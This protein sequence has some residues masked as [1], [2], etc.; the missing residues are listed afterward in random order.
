[1]QFINSK[2]EFKTYRDSVFSSS[3]LY[4]TGT[5]D[6]SISSV[7]RTLDAG[8][9]PTGLRG[10]FAFVFQNEKRV[11]GAVDHVATTNLFYTNSHICHIF[12]D[13]DDLTAK[14]KYV[15]IEYQ[16]RF[17]WGG[18]VGERTINA[19]I[20]RLEPGTYFEKDLESNN[21]SIHT[22][23]DLYTHHYDPSISVGDIADITEQIIEEQTREPF[24]LLWSSGTDSNCILGFI[25]KLNRTDNCRLI[26]LYSEAS[27]TDERPQCK[28]LESVYGLEAEYKDLGKF[29]GITD[30]VIGR[31]R[32]D[33]ESVEYKKNF[34]RTWRGFWFEPNVFQKYTTLYDMGVHTKPTFTGE[35]GDQIFGSR[36]GKL[37]LNYLSHVPNPT[38]DDIGELFVSAD[39]FRFKRA[40]TIQ[41]PSWI[42]SL[43]NDAGRNAGWNEA[44]SWVSQ[45][46]GEI[47]TGGDIVNKTELLQYL[48]KG[49]HRVFNYGQLIDCDFRHPFTD[50]RLFHTVFKT[51]GHWKIT[52]GK[53]R[54]LS[55]SIINDFVDPGPWTW[56][57]SGIQVS[58]QQ[59]YKPVK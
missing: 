51:P 5:F 24:N 7:F 20:M 39:A 47:D 46:W 43:E 23:I 30:E 45:K 41:Y 56:A 13:L 25:R 54:R 35:V 2:P 16:R 53:T 10:N 28:Y 55:L 17:F 9:F 32:S 3:V 33:S 44:K 27:I 38:N 52:N 57:K 59:I 4:Y 22:Y 34:K 15:P 40:A 6:Q 36:F 50:Y 12:V 42:Q 21:I 19:D 1:M 49:S 14:Q 48:Y 26:S 37:L 29:I 11:V 31:V 58:M 18:S 8:R